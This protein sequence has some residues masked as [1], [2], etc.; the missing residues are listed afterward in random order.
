MNAKPLARFLYANVPGVATLR[1]FAKDLMAVKFAKLEYQ[2]VCRFSAENAVIIDIGANRGQSIAAFKALGRRPTIV[3][4][5]PEPASAARLIRHYQGDAS[6][7]IHACALGTEPGA[8]T[9]FVPAYGWWNCDGMAAMDRDTATSWLRDPGRMYLFDESKL[10]VRE[11]RIECRTLDSFEL[12]P[13][14]I[15]LHA[16]GAELAILQGAVQ[17]LT[18]HLPALM[19]AFATPELTCFL[20]K[21]GF[22][23]YIYSHAG[24]TAG[25]ARPPVTF[26]WYLT[27]Q[28]L[29]EHKFNAA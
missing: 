14:L 1:F 13:S 10:R 9:F 26:T 25:V 3:A 23:P 18:K 16:Q 6:V 20:S 8:I 5:E 28:H 22:H 7:T 11:Y 24:F 19:C 27:E 2:G 21:Y 29:R 17:T 15:K 12:S 4:F